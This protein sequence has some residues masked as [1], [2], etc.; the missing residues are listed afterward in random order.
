LNDVEH[1]RFVVRN[2]VCHL[3][4]DQLGYVDI[5]GTL[6]TVVYDTLLGETMLEKAE[7]LYVKLVELTNIVFRKSGPGVMWVCMSPEI[8]MHFEPKVKPSDDDVFPTGGPDIMFMGIIERK[9]VVFV[10]PL[11]NQEMMVISNGFQPQ[12]SEP[13][14]R[15]RFASL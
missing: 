6:A 3:D 5:R 15:K 9:W 4:H 7:A 2:Y 13:G 11:L 12:T 10:D 14:A 1:E 8:Y